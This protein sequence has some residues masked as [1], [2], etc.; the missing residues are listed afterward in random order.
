M[1]L[2]RRWR[3]LQ[4]SLSKFHYCTQNSLF[5]STQRSPQLWGDHRRSRWD[6]SAPTERHLHPASAKHTGASLCIFCEIT[7][8]NGERSPALEA[9]KVA[10]PW[11]LGE[12]FPLLG[13]DHRHIHGKGRSVYCLQEGD[14]G[15]L[16]SDSTGPV[17]L[18][19]GSC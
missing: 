15:D 9:S 18:F 12:N 1:S 14:L 10:K 17:D 19:Q 11:N 7:D 4:T 6:A 2:G 16:L 13:R 3:S 8:A 5:E